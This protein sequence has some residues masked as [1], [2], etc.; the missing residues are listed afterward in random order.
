LSFSCTSV[1]TAA[2]T[3]AVFFA[4][5]NAGEPVGVAEIE[6]GLEAIIGKKL[7]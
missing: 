6:G 1:G 4:L 3:G 7:I 5:F 2:G